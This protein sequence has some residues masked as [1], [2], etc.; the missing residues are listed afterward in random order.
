[1]W[2][3][4]LHCILP[5]LPRTTT[6]RAGDMRMPTTSE[7]ID[8]ERLLAQARGAAERAY[9]PYS[10]FRV[11]AAVVVATARGPRVVTG[12][13]VENASYGLTLCA[14][15]AA[16][17]AACAL[18]DAARPSDVESRGASAPSIT[19]VALACVDAP[20]TRRPPAACRVAPVVNGSQ[21]W[22]RTPRSSSM[23]S[24]TIS[25]WPI[26]CRSRSS[27][28]HPSLP[29]ADSS[30]SGGRAIPCWQLNFTRRD[31]GNRQASAIRLMRH[32]RRA[33]IGRAWRLSY[34]VA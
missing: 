33:R 24:Q 11:G 9:A 2:A 18:P 26:Y 20:P 13:N 19:H 34:L 8:R 31:R 16:L 10:H 29:I 22:R 25:R 17:A 30:P 15:R 27:W 14:E 6:T 3:P 5:A 1:M 32:V 12:A 23:A 7:P 28:V 4:P 21:N